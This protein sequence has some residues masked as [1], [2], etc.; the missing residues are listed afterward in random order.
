MH[1]K[2][3][4]KHRRLS[5]EKTILI[6][7]YLVKPTISY[8]FSLTIL[9]TYLRVIICSSIF[10]APMPVSLIHG[11]FFLLRSLKTHDLAKL[12]YCCTSYAFIHIRVICTCVFN[13]WRRYRYELSYTTFH[14]FCLAI[15]RLSPINFLNFLKPIFL[16]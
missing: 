3:S 4:K 16:K 1:T 10:P 14:L 15:H 11:G 12:I 6:R 2:R 9:W 7:T 8:P 13:S 5:T